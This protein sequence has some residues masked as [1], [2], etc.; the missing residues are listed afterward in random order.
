MTVYS[1][2]VLD[3]FRNPRN[4]GEIEDPDGIAQIGDPECGDFL[5]IT[6]RVEE[7]RITDIKFLCQGCPA[8]I[9]CASVTT[10]LARGRHIDEAW[11]V[12]DDAVLEAL[13]A[14]PEQKVHCSLLAPTALHAAIMNYV[15][16]SVET[17]RGD[18]SLV[19]P[20]EAT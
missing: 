5:R 1:E 16:R 2:R 18:H 3:H 8:A 6:L 20:K 9:A 19:E 14:L 11:N 12:T 7:E 15:V 10:E 13:G 17:D 4:V